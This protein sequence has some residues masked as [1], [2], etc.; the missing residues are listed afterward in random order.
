MANEREKS[1][2]LEADISILVSGG[3][4]EIA[5][6]NDII[7]SLKNKLESKDIEALLKQPPTAGIYLHKI[8][9]T[10]NYLSNQTKEYLSSK[11]NSSYYIQP[12]KT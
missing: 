3:N 2:Q 12:S 4:S 7:N 9:K 8:D 10:E 6:L 5:E 11:Q 1:R